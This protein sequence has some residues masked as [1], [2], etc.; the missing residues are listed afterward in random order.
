MEFKKQ[1]TKGGGGGK[2]QIEKQTLSCREQATTYQR[3]GVGG[4]WVKEGKGIKVCSCCDE[5]Q[6]MYG[7][8]DSLYSTPET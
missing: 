3:G 8:F 5:R 6:V 7:S 2:R 4:R 1:K